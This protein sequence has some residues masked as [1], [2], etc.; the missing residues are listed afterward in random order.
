MHFMRELVDQG[1]LRTDAA[2]RAL[3]KFPSSH[4]QHIPSAVKALLREWDRRGWPT[5]KRRSPQKKKLV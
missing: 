2:R 1:S 4:Y 3:Q 5:P